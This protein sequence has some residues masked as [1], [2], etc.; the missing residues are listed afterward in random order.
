MSIELIV[1]LV[2]GFLIG[3]TLVALIN[4][5]KI[6]DDDGMEQDLIVFKKIIDDEINQSSRNNKI[7]DKYSLRI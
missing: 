3:V 4:V 6:K 2:I 7:N 5:F 1:G